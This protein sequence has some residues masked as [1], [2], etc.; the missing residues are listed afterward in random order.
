M[1]GENSQY[2]IIGEWSLEETLKLIQAVEKAT[3]I[4]ILYPLVKIKFKIKEDAKKQM[5]VSD[6]KIKIY[7]D[8]VK[9]KDIMS[10]VVFDIQNVRK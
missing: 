10:N 6:E 5:K 8:Q 4:S 3:N 7:S 1:G 2:K 9:F